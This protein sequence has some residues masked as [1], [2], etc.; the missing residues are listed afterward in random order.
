MRYV[1]PK[2]LRT[3][4]AISVIQQILWTSP[5]DKTCGIFLDATYP[6]AVF[7]TFFAYEADE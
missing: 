6:D 2:I 5:S 7:C 4:C 3:C 1:K